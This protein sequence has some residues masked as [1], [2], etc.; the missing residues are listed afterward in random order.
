VLEYNPGHL[1]YGYI[2]RELVIVRHGQST[3]NE[4]EEYML[5]HKSEVVF[6]DS[7]H[8]KQELMDAYRHP[9]RDNPLND[10]ILTPLGAQQCKDNHISLRTALAR[11]QSREILALVSPY[12]RAAET[13][14]GISKGLSPPLS[15]SIIPSLAET[16][17]GP[18]LYQLLGADDLRDVRNYP[19]EDR[20]G[21]EE[22]RRRAFYRRLDTSACVKYRASEDG[23]PMY[24]SCLGDT[25][26]LS[27][28]E[29]IDHVIDMLLKNP[30]LVERQYPSMMEEA[31]TLNEERRLLGVQ[32]R[33]NLPLVLMVGHSNWFRNLLQTLV[34]QLPA[35]MRDAKLDPR[36][37]TLTLD[38]WADTKLRNAEV[39]TLKIRGT[40]SGNVH[41]TKIESF[42]RETTRASR[43]T[44]SL[45]QALTRGANSMRAISASVLRPNLGSSQFQGPD[46][47]MV[48]DKCCRKQVDATTLDHIQSKVMEACAYDAHRR[49]SFYLDLIDQLEQGRDLD[50]TQQ[51]Q[52]C[53]EAVKAWHTHYEKC[54]CRE[55]DFWGSKAQK[56]YN[57]CHAPSSSGS[58]YPS[59]YAPSSSSPE[60]Y[61]PR[62]IFA[63]ENFSEGP[64]VAD[65]PSSSSDYPSTYT[66][67]SPSSDYPS[68]YTSP[69]SSSDYS[70]AYTPSL[71][72]SDYPST[73]NYHVPRGL[74]QNFPSCY[75]A[76]PIG[77]RRRGGQNFCC[78]MTDG[79][80]HE[81]CNMRQGHVEA[82]RVGTALGAEQERRLHA[83]FQEVE[84]RMS[85]LSRQ[86]RERLHI[87]LQEVEIQMSGGEG[88]KQIPSTLSEERPV[89]APR[90]RGRSARSRADTNE[91]ARYPVSQ[92]PE[93]V[94]SFDRYYPKTP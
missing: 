28:K 88:G 59:T 44:S 78:P 71:P 45:V 64:Y 86:R 55:Q 30:G 8:R 21:I 35:A 52:G 90:N 89:A 43:G 87:L 82:P 46:S 27:D 2:E 48:D 51:T 75:Y 31:R 12:R 74:C 26:A 94:L 70:G 49:M 76:A 73:Y 79:S 83:L 7:E 11:S 80:F 17:S 14:E 9:S 53:K 60:D 34:R 13:A 3:W 23:A 62:E 68:T 66:P 91:E 72:S 54:D 50:C 77:F 67:P 42:Y 39:V 16:G 63:P 24:D 25:F 29:R 85:D 6:H 40:G 19:K 58:E 38:Q 37:S 61:Y 22:M 41:V 4:F 18:D 81:C 32:S 20:D 57:A 56:A 33:H 65:T 69:S 36:G 93:D 5:S 15:F 1:P 92:E 47:K 84:Q 10:P